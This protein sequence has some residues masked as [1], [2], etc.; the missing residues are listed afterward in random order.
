MT[1]GCLGKGGRGRKS[2]RHGNPRRKP[3]SSYFRIKVR[4]PPKKKW[5]NHRINFPIIILRKP[6]HC[7][8]IIQPEGFAMQIC[9]ALKPLRLSWPSS[10]VQ[11]V[12]R[13][14]S[15]PIHQENIRLLRS[16]KTK[17]M[18]FYIQM[19]QSKVP[20]VR[21]RGIS[22]TSEAIRYDLQQVGSEG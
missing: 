15:D 8:Q 11:S 7:A 5:N 3:S 18:P 2:C 10:L 17:H 21:M 16:A 12:V 14:S 20:L 6:K 4:F 13:Y 22:Q 1:C 19:K 9:M